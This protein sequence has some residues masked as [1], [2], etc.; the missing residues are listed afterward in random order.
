MPVTSFTLLIFSVLCAAAITVWAFNSLGAF[1][2]LPVLLVLGLLA[3]WG[4]GH[5]PHDDTRP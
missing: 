4:L 5:V 3:R 1:T 2:V